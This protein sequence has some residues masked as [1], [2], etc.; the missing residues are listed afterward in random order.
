[1]VE[2]VFISKRYA[3]SA[4]DISNFVLNFVKILPPS[5]IRTKNLSFINIKHLQE[6]GEVIQLRSV[7]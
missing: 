5:K 4:K 2:Y 6:T 3:K 1:M 7:H